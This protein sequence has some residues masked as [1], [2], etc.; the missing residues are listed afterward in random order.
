MPK[1][2]EGELAHLEMT[3]YLSRS[4]HSFASSSLRGLVTNMAETTHLYP[5]VIPRDVRITPVIEDNAGR[6]VD[7]LG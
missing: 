4:S 7:Q 2:V 6:L 3:S 5:D 1:L